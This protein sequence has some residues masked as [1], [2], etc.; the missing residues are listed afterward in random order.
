MTFEGGP[1]TFEERKAFLQSINQFVPRR[2][3]TKNKAG[4][5]IG[6]KAKG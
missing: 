5:T 6:V 2:R 1:I 4:K 3:S